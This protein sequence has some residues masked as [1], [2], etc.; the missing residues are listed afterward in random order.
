MEQ[1]KNESIANPLENYTFHVGTAPTDYSV[2]FEE[3]LF[4][5]YE[6]RILQS[7]TGWHSFFILDD[8]EKKICGA[9]HFHVLEGVALSP[10]RSPFGSL[11]FADDLDQKVLSGFIEY[12]QQ[13][14]QALNVS[15]IMIK[16]PPELYSSHIRIFQDLLCSKG[17]IVSFNELDSAI[18]IRGKHYD[19]II[20][21]RKRRRLRQIFNES[22]EFKLL[23]YQSLNDVYNFIHQ[24]REEKGMKLSMTLDDL[25]KT[26]SSFKNEYPLFGVYHSNELVAASVTVRVNSKI[27]YHFISDYIRKTEK[28]APGLVL[29]QGIYNYCVAQKITLLDLGTSQINDNQN[30]TLI[31]FKKE[32]GGIE[33]TKCTLIKEIAL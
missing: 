12:F 23:D 19:E 28:M 27:L 16:N 7:L 6:H 21:A 20:H 1:G 10:L 11:E 2:A 5:S 17:F 14:L 24:R 22:L 8:R 25:S 4:N 29:M 33:N 32:I 18:L 15:K 26:V 3:S 13:Q 30:E 31:R 9:I